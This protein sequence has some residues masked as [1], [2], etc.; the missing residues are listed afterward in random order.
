MLD[1]SDEIK[2]LSE[3]IEASAE[4]LGATRAAIF[5]W[6]QRGIPGDWKVRLAT[7][8]FALEQVNV[9]DQWRLAQRQAAA[10]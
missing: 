2:T 1:M 6:R 5:K 10:E 8:G 7:S 4:R 9:V 3:K